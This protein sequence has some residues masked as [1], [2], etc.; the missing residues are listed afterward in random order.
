[1]IKKIIELWIDFILEIK[2][3]IKK[4]KSKKK[5]PFIYK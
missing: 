1:M 3:I 4:R 2:Y 5:D